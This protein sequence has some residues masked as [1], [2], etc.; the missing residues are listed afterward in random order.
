MTDAMEAAKR[1]ACGCKTEICIAGI[2]S[3]ELGAPCAVTM[4][5]SS[6]T[7]AEQLKFLMMPPP[8]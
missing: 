6:A 8:R 1:S 3:F 5:Q 4:L 2:N 7:V